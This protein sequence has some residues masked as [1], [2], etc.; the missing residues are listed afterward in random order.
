MMRETSTTPSPTALPRVTRV[1]AYAIVEDAD[2]RLLLC[3][4]REGQPGAG[5]WSLPGGGLEFGEAPEV[6]VLRE[7]AEETGL[8]GRVAGILGLTSRTLRGTRPTG[9]QEMHALGICYR[10]VVVGGALRDEQDNSTDRAAWFTREEV[11]ALPV[12]HLVTSA[13]GFLA[14]E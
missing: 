8:E 2:G 12:T 11:A 6:G 7:L 10:A 13:L 9:E 5:R 3:R 1:A 14:A 4:M